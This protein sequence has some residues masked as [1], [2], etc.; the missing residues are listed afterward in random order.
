MAII[1]GEIIVNSS[2]YALFETAIMDGRE[3]TMGY[4]RPKKEVL[5]SLCRC[6]R[7]FK[8][9]ANIRKRMRDAKTGVN[10]PENGNH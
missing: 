3:I 5:A 10:E 4:R 6:I 7:R 9:E 8:I 2:E 1:E